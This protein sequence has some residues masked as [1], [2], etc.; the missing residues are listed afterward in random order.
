M[1]IRVEASARMGRLVNGE[2]RFVNHR[3]REVLEF[4]HPPRNDGEIR[5]AIEKL[6]TYNSVVLLDFEVVRQQ[7]VDAST[8]SYPFRV[9][10]ATPELAGS[11]TVVFDVEVTPEVDASATEYLDAW[12]KTHREGMKITRIDRAGGGTHGQWYVYYQ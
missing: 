4:A 8:P 10:D 3:I 5:D 7:V 9:I 1:K 6:P 2:M 12:M 11:C